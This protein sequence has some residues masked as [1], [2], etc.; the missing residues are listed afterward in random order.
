[1]LWAAKNVFLD[2]TQGDYVFGSRQQTENLVA[3]LLLGHSDLLPR[4]LLPQGVVV[5]E[6]VI[7]L[8]GGLPAH[9]Q[10]I[11]RALEQLQALWGNHCRQ[12]RNR[13]ERVSKG[14]NPD[15]VSIP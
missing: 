11:L 3:V 1:M 6:I 2:V 8:A 14:G 12:N 9:Q 4:Q 5:E 15:P 13:E 7:H 10:R